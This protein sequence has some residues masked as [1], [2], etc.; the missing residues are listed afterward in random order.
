MKGGAKSGREV[1]EEE[2]KEEEEEK[3]RWRRG[4]GGE[5]DEEVRATTAAADSEGQRQERVEEER[6]DEEEDAEEEEAD[7]EGESEGV[8]VDIDVGDEVSDAA[9]AVEVTGR[10]RHR[11]SRTQRRSG[12]YARVDLSGGGGEGGGR[13]DAGA[14]GQGRGSRQ[15]Q[16]PR[17]REAAAAIDVDPYHPPPLSAP[18]G[19]ALP[20]SS[21]SSPAVSGAGGAGA[22][23]SAA[24][25]VT[26]PSAPPL[27]LSSVLIAGAGFM[28]D[29]YDLFIMNVVLVVMGC[30]ASSHE[31][32]AAAGVCELSAGDKGSLA[33][34]VL[35]GSIAGQLSFGVLA[36]HLGRRRG[37]ILTLSILIVGA[38]LS[39][40]AQPVG[41]L[42]LVVVLSLARFVLGV[43]VGGEYPLSATVSSEASSDTAGRG[44]RVSLVFSMQGVGLV[45]APVVVLIL[46]ATRLP[47]DAVWRVSLGL[48]ALP[49]V[50]MI[51]FRCRMKETEA[52][53]AAKEEQRRRKRTER[54]A[55]E[56]ATTSIEGAE[57]VEGEA[58]ESPAPLS[59]AAADSSAFASSTLVTSD[60]A[61]LLRVSRWDLLAT[62][63]NW[64]IFDVVFYAN[65]LFSSE[66]T[67]A[68][69][70]TPS[71]ASDAG[72]VHAYLQQ[73]ATSTLIL[74]LCALP[75]YFG[76]TMVI[77]R[78]GRRRLQLFGYAGMCASYL[79]CAL[80]LRSTS[81]SSPPSE[82]LFYALYGL[83]F[84]FSNMGPNTTTFVIPA[85]IFP[86]LIRS[87]C[88]G[89]SAASGKVGAAIGTALMPALFVWSNHSLSTVM[90]AS[91]CISLIGFAFTAA[92]TRESQH[93]DIAHA[94]DTHSDRQRLTRPGG[95]TDLSASP[96]SGGAKHRP[97]VV[98]M[99]SL[100]RPLSSSSSSSSSHSSLP[101]SSL[102]ATKRSRL[103][104][105][106][107]VLRGARGYTALLKAQA[108]EEEEDV[109]AEVN[110]D[111]E[112][113]GE[114]AEMGE[115]EVVV[116]EEGE[117]EE[118]EAR[119][120]GKPRNHRQP[121]KLPPPHPRLASSPAP[122][123]PPPVP[124]PIVSYSTSLD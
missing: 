119:Y 5:V 117:E 102:P 113:G 66:V 34:A 22:P 42:S 87:T 73:V 62:A 58:Q 85:E 38:L 84:F 23:L 71:D 7:A 100:M 92:L 18:A 69:I 70:P 40:L 80:A 15:P 26:P 12:A 54:R 122:I 115:E 93:T 78:W 91:A 6:R 75:G 29:A 79:V 47:Y 27:T 104:F 105:A 120:D 1:T 121:S 32:A 46:L 33:S 94:T 30:E 59:A 16:P 55:G 48:G 9:G 57:G 31:G 101:L 95:S 4:R 10:R 81:A 14:W 8:D 108:E 35:V 112:E 49:G 39:S 96:D 72:A 103:S 116:M 25:A 99:A 74:G 106:H 37:F 17:S 86:T 111:E 65:A 107:A 44:Q 52:F 2:E 67:K 63:G 68:I 11:G 20:P 60:K 110:I 24:P 56:Q 83:S 43:G 19:H 28:C 118:D 77:D 51:F 13:E 88:H 124:P 64:F 45:L 41:A 114:Q 50:V 98:T 89:I 97:G 61:A 123:S 82:P 76:A 109:Q 53:T 21:S 90:G 3:R 36:D